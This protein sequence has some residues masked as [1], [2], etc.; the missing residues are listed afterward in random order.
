MIERFS[1]REREV[2]QLLAQGKSN[3]QIAESLRIEVSTVES[4]I[5]HVLSKLGFGSRTEIVVWW[6]RR[7]N[8]Q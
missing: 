8:N 4:H 2:I 1:N 6:L 7:G 5:H 3:A